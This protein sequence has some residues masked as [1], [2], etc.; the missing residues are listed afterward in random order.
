MYFIITLIH[1]YN[2]HFTISHSH[3]IRFTSFL[4]FQSILSASDL[5]ERIVFNSW[6]TKQSNPDVYGS[7]IQQYVVKAFDW[8]QKKSIEISKIGNICNI[9]TYTNGVRVKEEFCVRLIYCLS[10]ALEPMH[11]SE[12]ATKVIH[13]L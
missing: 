7:L 10:Y 3:L 8:L 11:Q 4:Q 12:L 5:S 6:S 13:H 1:I 2:L 9:L